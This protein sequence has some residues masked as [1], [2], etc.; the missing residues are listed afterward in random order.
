MAGSKSPG[1]LLPAVLARVVLLC[2][3]AGREELP[4][5]ET[6]SKPRLVQVCSAGDLRNVEGT[7][8]AESEPNRQKAPYSWDSGLCNPDVSGQPTAFP[9]LSIRSTA[10]LHNVTK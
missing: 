1:D 2:G 4:A 6:V 9:L 3:R 5:L 8:G 10:R 7:S